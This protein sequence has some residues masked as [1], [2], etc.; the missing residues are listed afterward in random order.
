[1]SLP[2]QKMKGDNIMA[3]RVIIISDNQ[4]NW[5]ISSV[6]KRVQSAA[7]AY[8]KATG[9]DVWVHA[10]DLQGYGTQQFHGAKTNIIAG[11]SEKIFDFIKIAEQGEGT[12][13]EAIEQYI[14]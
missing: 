4:C 6:E 12:L 11:W 5:G 1:M 2:F 3:D 13:E 14:Y 9:N 10:I 7:D 8:R